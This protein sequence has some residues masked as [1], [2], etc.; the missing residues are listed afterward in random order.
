M[1]TTNKNTMKKY[2]NTAN[3]FI[4]AHNLEACAEKWQ[5]GYFVLAFSKGEDNR[6]YNTAD[7]MEY[8]IPRRMNVREFVTL[9][10][11]G[12]VLTKEEVSSLADETGCLRSM[13]HFVF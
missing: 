12:K 13:G 4:Q 2:M 6:Y 5:D 3:Y 1:K 11:L 8:M 9:A 10:F 7:G